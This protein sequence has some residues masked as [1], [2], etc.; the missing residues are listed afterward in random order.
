MLLIDQAVKNNIISESEER[1][2][3]LS[4]LLINIMNCE[5]LLL[6]FL[7]QRQLFQTEMSTHIRIKDVAYLPQAPRGWNFC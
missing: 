3:K 5:N 1:V 7:V 4:L 2:V 6:F